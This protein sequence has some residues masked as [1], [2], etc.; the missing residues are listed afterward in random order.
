VRPERIAHRRDEMGFLLNPHRHGT[1]AAPP[2]E[3]PGRRGAWRRGVA[4]A[5]VLQAAS[6]GLGRP[7]ALHLHARPPSYERKRAGH[8]TLITFAKS[9]G[10][11]ERHC[12]RSAVALSAAATTALQ[13][14]RS[15]AADERR[16]HHHRAR[17]PSKPPHVD[18]RSH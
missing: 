7:L 10:S 14:N 8:D 15:G 18:S 6:L 13:N 2:S 3:R 9:G 5:S 12:G 1:V 4:F 17:K 11:P 16:P